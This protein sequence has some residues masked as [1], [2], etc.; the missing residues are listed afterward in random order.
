MDILL[1]EPNPN[2]GVP[3]HRKAFGAQN[4]HGVGVTRVQP[5]VSGGV[6]IGYSVLV[7]GWVVRVMPRAGVLNVFTALR[8][9]IA[10]C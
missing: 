7:R 1:E 4:K 9:G 8:K 2:V 10:A 6:A 5:S 3:V